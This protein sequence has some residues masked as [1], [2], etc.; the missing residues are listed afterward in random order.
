MSARKIFIITVVC[1]FL[2]SSATILPAQKVQD[3]VAVAGVGAG[4]KLVVASVS[5]PVTAVHG[6]ST[7][8]TFRVTNQGTA[9]SGSYKVGLYLSRDRNIQP[10]AD[11]LLDKITVLAG[12][13]PGESRKAT[14]KVVVPSNGLSGNYYYGAVVAG[15]KKASAGQVFLARYSLADTLE[16]V[17]DHRTGLVWEQADDG[18]TRNWDAANQYCD[19]LVLGG[20]SDWRLPA[21]EELQTLIDFSRHQPAIDPIFFCRSGKYWSSSSVASYTEAAWFVD[22]SY[23]YLDWLTKP[24]AYYARCVRGGA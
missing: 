17:T 1:L 9:V 2:G 12:L 5:G 18:Q 4:A 21:M 24:L 22:F 11:R 16:T 15:S 23:G 8:V 7:P 13:A 20:H 3:Q 10:A 6:Q 19:D 14:A